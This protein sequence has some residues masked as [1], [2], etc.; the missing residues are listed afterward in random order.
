MNWVILIVIYIVGMFPV[1]IFCSF[2]EDILR[3]KSDDYQDIVLLMWPIMLPILIFF[4]IYY[5]ASEFA[6]DIADK[7]RERL[8]K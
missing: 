6:D 3:V 1:M 5:Y 4:I 8:G 7:I 2:F